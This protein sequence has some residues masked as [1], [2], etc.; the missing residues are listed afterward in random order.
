[1]SKELDIYVSR[2]QQRPVLCPQVTKTQF[3]SA[4]STNN[5]IP[6]IKKNINENSV[7]KTGTYDY[8]NVN[9]YV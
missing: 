1:M 9:A 6:L 7:D 8:I 2:A 5:F 3:W 4:C